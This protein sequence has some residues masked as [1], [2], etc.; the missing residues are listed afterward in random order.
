[1][2]KII[3]ILLMMLS[4]ST[5]AATKEQCKIANEMLELDGELMLKIKD[6]LLAPDFDKST[7]DEWTDEFLRD[8]ITVIMMHSLQKDNSEPVLLAQTMTVKI[9]AFSQLS[10]NY[11]ADK[12]DQNK[13]LVKEMV[14]NMG[15]ISRRLNSLCPGYKPKSKG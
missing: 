10:L 3:A 11:V 7:T 14:A 9:F 2:K 8:Y 12:S 4:V 15:E 1:M 13:K 5:F 6:T